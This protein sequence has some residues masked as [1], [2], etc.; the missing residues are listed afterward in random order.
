MPGWLSRID[1]SARDLTEEAVDFARRSPLPEPNELLDH[2]FYQDGQVAPSRK[3]TRET[4]AQSE[5]VC[6]D[7]DGRENAKSVLQS[8]AVHSPADGK[9]E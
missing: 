4:A 8:L 3:P 5:A 2:V 9:G 7:K 1:R 6:E